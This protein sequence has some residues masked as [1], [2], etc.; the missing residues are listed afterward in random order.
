MSKK[1]S[2]W[3]R[4][5]KTGWPPGL[6]QDDSRE[7]SRWFASRIDAR[8]TIRR[9]FRKEIKMN[10]Q[11]ET[12]RTTVTMEHML[13]KVQKTVYTILPDTTTTICQLLLRMVML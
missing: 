11:I 1:K 2:N 6:L 4:P 13:S 7:L 12:K 5:P 3:E 9:V 10:E 8:E